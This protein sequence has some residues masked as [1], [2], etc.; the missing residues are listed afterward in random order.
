[1][2]VKSYFTDFVGAD[3]VLHCKPH[4]NHLETLMN[5]MGVDCNTTFY[6]GDTEVDR[7]CAHSANTPF[8]IVPWGGGSEIPQGTDYKINRLS[9]LLTYFT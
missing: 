5:T 1:M 4:A 3:A 7:A 9:D 6:V 8:F 2:G